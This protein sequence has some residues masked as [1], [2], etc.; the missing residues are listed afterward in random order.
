MGVGITCCRCGGEFDERTLSGGWLDRRC[1]LCGERVSEESYDALAADV[2][3]RHRPQL[4]KR[5]RRELDRL[6][7]A[8]YYTSEWFR[9]AH[10][11]QGSEAPDRGLHG[12]HPGYDEDT[13][14]FA[15]VPGDDDRS[16]DGGWGASA[17]YAVF[18]ALRA[19]IIR[20]GSPLE[21]A[22]LI[23]QLVFPWLPGQKPK[24]WG[25]KHRAEVDCLLICK[26]CAIV[27]E[28]KRRTHHVHA[29]RDC[30]HMR[31]RT[32]DGASYRSASEVAEQVERGAD[33]FAERQDRYPRERIFT[34]VVYVDPLSFECARSSFID[35]R[36]VSYLDASGQPH[37][38]EALR[39]QVAQYDDIVSDADL[40]EL[41]AHMMASF[42]NTHEPHQGCIVR[43]RGP[44]MGSRMRRTA[45]MLNTIDE[46]TRNERSTLLGA[47]LLTNLECEVQ[48]DRRGGTPKTKRVALPGLLLTRSHAVLID[49]KRWP[50]HVNTHAP[51]ATVY[52]GDPA[53]GAKHVDDAIRH[54][55]DLQAIG[56]RNRSGSLT[57][58]TFVSKSI[59]ELERYRERNRVCRMNVFVD[60]ETFYSDG[61]AFKQKAFIGF[62]KGKR[63]N[64]VTA[65]EEL[66]SS[67]EPVMTQK[68]LD[69]LAAEI[70]RIGDV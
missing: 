41:A 44:N 15:L 36:F 28:V 9:L 63:N 21:G 66:A 20:E 24:Q 65:L 25:A 10:A 8:R 14:R 49:A 68:Q 46:C 69:K 56:Y 52:T 30:A 5:G 6:A 40:H 33:S 18:D 55:W 59:A 45:A 16:P 4:G 35:G 31:E 57:L 34:M 54:D 53:E 60:P 61:S 64:I 1:P 38:M 17:E 70:A 39:N 2:F 22:L 19:E 3:A 51:F 48:L 26:S 50:A 23:P 13:Q 42:G 67:A 27:F 58:L 29:S 47:H 11:G 12:L 37:F 43:G 62:W 7:L 32:A